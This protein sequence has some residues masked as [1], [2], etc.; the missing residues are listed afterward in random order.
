MTWRSRRTRQ[1]RQTGSDENDR[2]GQLNGPMNRADQCRKLGIRQVLN[3]ID[4]EQQATAA[5][6]RG[7]ADRDQ[8]I[9]Y[10]LGQN[11]RIGAAGNRIDIERDRR[12]IREVVGKGLGRAERSFDRPRNRAATELQQ[13]RAKARGQKVLKVAGLGSLDESSDQ[14]LLLG[15]LVESVEQN[16]L[17]DSPQPDRHD[18]LSRSPGDCPPKGYPVA[19]DEV[20]ATHECRWRS[21]CSRREWIVDS[22]HF[23][24]PYQALSNL[25]S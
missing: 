4:C 1:L 25:P 16:G 10:V 6:V 18:A 11:P 5:I 12:S 2:Q 3:L 14:L 23:K 19:L 8:Q 15:H 9:G 21:T 13:N 22:I 17:T 24:G 7:L 20:L